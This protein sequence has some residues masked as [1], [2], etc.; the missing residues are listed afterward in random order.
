MSEMIRDAGMIAGE[1]NAI[2]QEVRDC[3][4]RGAIEIGKRLMEA[5]SLVPFGEWGKWLADNVDYSERTAQE[6]MRIAK[7]YGR[8]ETQALAEI[9][10]TTQ[11]V[12]LLALDS[13]ER[14]RFV[15][16]HDMAAMST[17]ELEAEIER[18]K[19]ERR[20]AQMTLDDILSQIND[21][22]MKRDDEGGSH[23]GEATAEALEAANQRA[24]EL[25]QELAEARTKMT[26][27]EK[28]RLNDLR[29]EQDKAKAD[30]AER[31]KLR[32]ELAE[33]KKRAEAK[34][35]QL[36]RTEEELA[37]AREK[38]HTVEVVPEAVEKELAA[39]RRKAAASGA[40]SEMR[41]AFDTMKAAF[42]RL[43][44]K[45]DDAQTTDEETALK[46]R[47]AFYRAMMTMAERVK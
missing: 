11:A 45:L 2:K 46:Y 14:E 25:E 12:L 31:D 26:E 35:K 19:E 16:E 37:A 21:A 4:I 3:A 27:A 22:A 1:I 13:G 36:Q 29:V 38:V 18:L 28:R 7:E 24:A 5:K 34:E 44:E 23:Q 15:Q 10:N 43:M 39:L 17:R 40:E 6:M 47:G 8:R 33:A 32:T 9:Q 42:E 20:K 41:A 30:K